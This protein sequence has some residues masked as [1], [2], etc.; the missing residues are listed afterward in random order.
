M[1]NIL[2]I[3]LLSAGGSLGFVGAFSGFSL[4]LGARPHE[5]AMIGSL[6]STPPEEAVEQVE[7]PPKP[8]EAVERRPA[9][10]AGIGVLDVFQIASPY[11]SGELSELAE[12]L[13]RKLGEVDGRLAA[14]DERERRADDRE[15]FLGEQYATL[16]K[17]RTG[18]ETLGDEL[19]QRESEIER[20]EA[21]R[22]ARATESWSRLAQLFQKGD[23]ASQSARLRTYTPSEAAEILHQLKP[24]RAQ[25]LLDALT[26]D[27][28]KDYAEAYRLSEPR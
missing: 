4:A 27:A 19:D 22:D 17:L 16:A 26:G 21:A 24:A 25:E 14:L 18:L 2:K 20:D 3:G 15:Q 8:I 6:F 23:A 28:W 9:R 11:S 5:I 13:E 12:S 7:A 1:N 10:A